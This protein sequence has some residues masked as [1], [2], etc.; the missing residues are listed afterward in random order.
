[1]RNIKG[2][3]IE[4]MIPQ[5]VR[6]QREFSKYYEK[7]S[8]FDIFNMI[9]AQDFIENPKDVPPYPHTIA[10]EN[11]IP[12]CFG[13]LPD[14]SAKCCNNYRKDK[15]IQPLVFRPNIHDEVKYKAD[16]NIIWTE[17]PEQII[18]TLTTL[19]L[20]CIELK[21]IRRIWHYL[22]SQGMGCEDANREK[23]IDDLLIELG[24]PSNSQEINMQQMLLNFK[25]SNYWKLLEKYT[26]FNNIEIF[27]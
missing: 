5:S 13:N 11:L 12:S 19:G 26:Y 23:T 10:Y 6:T 8:L 25:K 22:A 16:G 3:T 2:T 9:L 24:T 20:D 1:M 17:D 7:E 21:A 27:E 4:H 14:G 18:P 15:T